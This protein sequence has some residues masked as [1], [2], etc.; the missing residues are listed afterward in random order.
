M[1][2]RLDLRH[3]KCFDILKLPLGELT[4]LSG[5]NA[6]GKSSIIQALA[7]LHQTLTE[8]EWSRR[9]MLN[10]RVLRLGT[11]LD[12]V[13]QVHGRDT[14]S[15][16]LAAADGTRCE[17]TFEGSRS[18]M[19]MLVGGVRYDDEVWAAQADSRLWRLL[20]IKPSP[21]LD[22]RELVERCR[23]LTYLTAER[24]GPQDSYPLADREQA[25]HVGPRGENTAALLYWGTGSHVL[26]SLRIGDTPPTRLRQV[27]ARMARFFPDFQVQVDRIR[28]VDAITLGVRTSLAVD[29]HRP[30]HTGFGVTQV[31][32][33]VVAALTAPQGSVLLLEN[34]EVH[35]HPAGQAAMGQFLAEVAAAGVQIIVETHSDHVL[36][37]IRRAVYDDT[38]GAADVV[39][40]FFSP[41]QDP[42][43]DVI[44]QVQ[45][46]TVSEDGSVATWPEGFFDQFDKDMEYLAG[47]S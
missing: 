18:D 43:P 41:R 34:P 28:G 35:L 26:D 23:T 12:V 47:W 30:V 13:D 29:F 16:G 22:A 27:E 32:P 38:L 19:S 39:L 8:H 2:T 44:P 3:F 5:T 36:N 17:W 9:L 42:G 25:P 14:C 31:L 4:L 24:L 7:L 1:L 45:S 40:H 15:I 20:P 6:S 21:S 46:P 10:G 33:I 37:G 11:V